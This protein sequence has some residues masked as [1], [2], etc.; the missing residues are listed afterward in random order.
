MPLLGKNFGP[1]KP[2]VH[3]KSVGV[4]GPWNFVFGVSLEFGA[5]DLDLFPRCHLG[6]V[7]LRSFQWFWNS[8]R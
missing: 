3:G 8:P 1:R 2:A 5:W 4:R 6:S 7:A